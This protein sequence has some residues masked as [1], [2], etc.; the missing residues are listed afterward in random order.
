[1]VFRQIDGRETVGHGGRLL[2]AR[3]EMRYL[4]LEGVSIAVV[5]NQSRTDTEV[6][7]RSLLSVALPPLPT[8]SPSATPPPASTPY[9]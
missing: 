3:S 4:P 2:G 9:P 7:V 8:P 6:I 5:S 1:V